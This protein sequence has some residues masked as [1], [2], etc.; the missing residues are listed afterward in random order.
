MGEWPYGD[1][2]V[3]HAVTQTGENFKVLVKA[4]PKACKHQEEGELKD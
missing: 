1:E 3:V 4:P 2:C